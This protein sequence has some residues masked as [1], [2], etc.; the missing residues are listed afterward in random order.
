MAPEI[1]L[2]R[3]KALNSDSLVLDP[4]AGSGTVLRAAVEQGLDCIG[5]DADP[6]A[7]LMAKVWTRRLPAGL[8]EQAAALADRARAESYSPPA[9]HT[10][11]PETLA[12]ANFWFEEKQYV[13]LAK[14]AAVLE[15][16][17]GPTADALKLALSRLIITKERG[18]SVARDTSHSR[19]HRVFFDNDFDVLSQFVLAARRIETRLRPNDIH[20]TASVRTGDARSLD[21]A[22]QSVDAVITSPP[23]LNAIDYMRGHRL[24]LIWL[25]YKLPVLRSIRSRAIGSEA[26]I[27]GLSHD[28]LSEIP[29][30]N[31]LKPRDRNIVQRYALD[32]EN[33]LA[34]VKRVLKPRGTLLLVVGNSV[35]KDV[36]VSNADI[37]VYG[38]LKN[39]L[40]VR[41][42][43]ERDLPMG[44]R[45]LPVSGSDNP[46]TKRMRT[47]TVLE[48]SA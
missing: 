37:N 43:F 44:S 36:N 18:A 20:G 1:V 46:L 12:F 42:R 10:E 9:W 47:E 13:D 29:S 19:P 11:C 27:K 22:D 35:I 17:Y 15:R 14:L 16:E 7:V 34:Q 31:Q 6:L 33:M 4:M 28:I 48:F 21:L 41:K 25:G 26:A 39:G 5:F 30:L 38:A 23:Y 2:D 8:G 45:Y 32:I 40:R 24:A 3:L